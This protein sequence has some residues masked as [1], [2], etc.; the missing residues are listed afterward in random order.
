VKK[1]PK[2]IFILSLADLL[3][4]CQA[5]F[6]SVNLLFIFVRNNDV[7]AYASVSESKFSRFVMQTRT[8]SINVQ[9]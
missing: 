4:A 7:R 2:K 9:V 8:L 6:W 1:G 3:P 5:L